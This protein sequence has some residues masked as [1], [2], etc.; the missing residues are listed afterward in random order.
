MK[1]IPPTLM[2]CYIDVG[3]HR[4]QSI[5]SIL[6]FR[7][8]A[9]IVS[10]EANP[11]LAGQLA[12]RYKDRNNIRIVAKGLGDSAGL[13]PL[14][15]PSYMGCIYDALASFNRESAVY[16]LNKETILRFDPAKL[17]LAEYECTVET[18]DMQHLAPV[19]IKVDVEGYTYNVLSGGRETLRQYEPILLVENF[20]GDSRTVQLAEELGYEEY[21][22][23]GPSFRKGTP[24]SGP[25]SFLLT[26]RTA[27]A[28]F[29]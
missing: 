20:R 21:Y 8:E 19:F 27:K 1:L 3:A 12:A 15:V 5:E 22:F 23:D 7:P 26:F 24:V 9:E 25:N 17:A 16:C 11:R 29:G 18:L 28:I 6:L 2:G 10:F 14:F 13:L 4:G